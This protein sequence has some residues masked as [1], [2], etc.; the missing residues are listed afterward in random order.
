MFIDLY[1]Y[2]VVVGSTNKPQCVTV[3]MCINL[4]YNYISNIDIPSQLHN[5]I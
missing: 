1:L 3:T 2:V 5:Y 4:C